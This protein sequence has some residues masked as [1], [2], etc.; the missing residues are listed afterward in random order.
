MNN[1]NAQ[2][3]I[4]DTAWAWVVR[5]HE[6]THFDAAGR[7]ELQRWLASDQRHCKQYDKACR[8]WMLSGLIP[9]A[10]DDQS[11]N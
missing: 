9:P 3:L 7:E 6:R 10:S 1:D 11:A 4:W 5:E 8:L 2:D